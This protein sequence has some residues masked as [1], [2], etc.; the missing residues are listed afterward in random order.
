MTLIDG[1]SAT[2]PTPV[3]VMSWLGRADPIR[4]GSEELP[5]VAPASG[6]LR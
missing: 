1:R 6:E 2:A 4:V 3:V 5:R